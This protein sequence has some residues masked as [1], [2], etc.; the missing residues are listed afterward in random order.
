[1]LDEILK[2]VSKAADK[3]EVK[4]DDHVFDM[5]VHNPE[6]VSQAMY[7]L[8][9]SHLILGR[10]E[11]IFGRL[12]AILRRS[13]LNLGRSHPILDRSH[14]ILGRSHLILGRSDIILGRSHSY[15]VGHT[16]TL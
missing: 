14:L 5:A 3:L 7:R 13:D 2:D 8:G 11:P 4:L 1:M 6:L 10:S 16:H 12:H 15:L 9:K